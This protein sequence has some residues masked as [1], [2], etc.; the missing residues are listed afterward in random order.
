MSSGVCVLWKQV[1]SL[2]CSDWEV[3]RL[4]HLHQN[5]SHDFLTESVLPGERFN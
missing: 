4:G 1:Q 5:L 2:S 3:P